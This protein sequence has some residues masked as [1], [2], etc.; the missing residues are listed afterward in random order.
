MALP[1]IDYPEFKETI[2]S[3]GK[4]VWFRPFT[5]KEEKILLIAEESDNYVD[6]L[7]ATKQVLSNCFKFDCDIDDLTSYDVNYLF[8]K[9][10]AKSVSPTSDI[11]Y[12]VMECP[13]NENNP[14]EKTINVS[15]NLEDVTLK[16]YDDKS[17]TYI[18]YEPKQK[19]AGGFDIKLGGDVGVILKHPGFKEQ[20]QLSK[21][22]NAS[23]DDLIKLCIL[24]FYDSD[25]VYTRDDFTDEEMN[26]FYDALISENKRKLYEFIN[27]IPN[28]RYEKTLKCSKCGFT[29]NIIYENLE[30]FFD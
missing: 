27:N 29:E 14:C 4:D 30:D 11:M 24:S 7:H 23:N 15:I 2:P 13:E 1:K 26:E 20:E 19:V 16:S 10:R 22:K 6:I 8:L 3:T 18:D 28:L 12:R 25:T 5:H 21:I 9:I 17:E